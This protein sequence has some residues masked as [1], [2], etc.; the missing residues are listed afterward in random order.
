V[1]KLP[2]SI[3]ILGRKI[4][5]HYVPSDKMAKDWGDAGGVWDVINRCIYI[6]AGV[7]R[8]T[9]I[10]WI[11]HELTHGLHTLTGIDQKLPEEFVEILCQCNATLIEDIIAQ[12]GKF[13]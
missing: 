10:Y 2:A 3:T 11:Y 6:D 4:P 7:P 9:Q 8:K 1:K 13:K 5:I 12:A